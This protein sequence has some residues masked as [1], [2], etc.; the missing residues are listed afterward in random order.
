MDL[1]ARGLG[2]GDVFILSWVMAVEV[3]SSRFTA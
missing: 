3:V 2:F 1:D